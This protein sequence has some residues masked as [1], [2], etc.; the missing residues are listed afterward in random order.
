MVSYPLFVSIVTRPCD[1]CG[2]SARPFRGIDRVDND[3]GYLDGNMVPCCKACN[4][5]KSSTAKATFL[6]HIAR[7]YEHTHTHRSGA[8][9]D[10]S[11]E[12]GASEEQPVA[13]E[14]Q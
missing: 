6:E 8:E 4:F 7:I 9:P 14:E 10:A 3:V 1:Y 11:E 2:E 5:L 12:P 13:S